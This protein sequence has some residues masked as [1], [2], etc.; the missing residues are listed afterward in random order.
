MT[1][2]AAVMLFATFV[3][4]AVRSLRHATSRFLWTHPTAY[5]V[6]RAACKRVG[7]GEA[8]DDLIRESNLVIGSLEPF[9]FDR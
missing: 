7:C 9:E 8:F 6:A 4:I 1:A 5:R 2:V 3:P